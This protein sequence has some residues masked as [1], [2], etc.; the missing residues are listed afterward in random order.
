MCS[1]GLGSSP[2]VTAGS[3]LT[4]RTG[5]FF[6]AVLSAVFVFAALFLPF[7]SATADLPAAPGACAAGTG[8]TV[9]VDFTDLGGSIETGCAIGDP[10]TGR[11]ALSSAGFSAVDGTPGL[12]CAID[13]QPDP[14]PTTFNGDYWSYWHAKPGAEWASYQVGA[15]S[16]KPDRGEVE[17]WRYSN[18]AV[19]PGITAAV[20]ASTIAPVQSHPPVQE[21]KT[22]GAVDGTLIVSAA[23]AGALVL[24]IVAAIVLRTRRRAASDP[25]QSNDRGDHGEGD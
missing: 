22:A 23:A 10:A 5:T 8:V 2:S 1:A 19:G 24:V 13:A 11:T 6:V 4:P 21:Q 25:A 16:S 3:A 15:D 7:S 12:I 20:A 14:C 9:V 18:G 17:G